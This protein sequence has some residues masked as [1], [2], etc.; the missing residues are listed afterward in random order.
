ME[1][2]R[3]G[4]GRIA[5]AAIVG[6]ALLALPIAA[7]AQETGPEPVITSAPTGVP[8]RGNAVIAGRL[9]G[10]TPGQQVDLERWSSR[11]GW[12]RIASR[13]T[14][15][16]NRVRF[17]ITEL[18]R[19]AGY[20]LHFA[21]EVAAYRASSDPSRITVGARLRLKTSRTHV[22]KGRRVRVYGTLYPKRSGRRVVLQQKIDGAW[23][24]V[25]RMRAGDGSFSTS[26][27]PGKPGYRRLRVRFAGDKH[28]RRARARRPI[29]VYSTALATW[30]GPGLYGNRTACGRRL[31]YDTLGVAHRSLPCGTKVNILYRGRT[32]TVPVIDRGPY[33]SAEWDLTEETAERLR[34]SGK[35]HIGT[36][37]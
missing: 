19:S 35:D 7:A 37:R 5:A 36:Q 3:A 30:Y 22:I 9:D 27:R 26:F 24:W 14:D 34:F 31:G 12:K 10:G 8:F 28:N 6:L 4:S 11:L 29:R 15:E 18:R 20:R 32:I 17:R 33:S 1:R 13:A 2:V 21:D 16:N 25:G 23:R